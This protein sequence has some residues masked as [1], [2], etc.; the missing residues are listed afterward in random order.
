M[1]GRCPL[2]VVVAGQSLVAGGSGGNGQILT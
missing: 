1:N 2:F